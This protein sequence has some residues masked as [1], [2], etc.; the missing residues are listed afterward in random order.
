MLAMKT[1]SELTSEYIQRHP[2]IK[3]CL[4]KDLINYSSLSRLISRELRIDKKTSK[5]AILV[6]ARRFREKLKSEAFIEGKVHSLLSRSEIEVKNRIAVFILEKDI[7][8]DGLDS[9]QKRARRENSMFYLLEGSDNHTLITSEKYAELVESK[10]RIIKKTFNLAL[11]KLISPKEVEN[12]P[13]WVSYLT[14]LFAENGVNIQEFLSCW[15][16]TLFVIKSQEIG[17]ALAF[18]GFD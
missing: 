16:D 14:S 1:T 10:G 15:T 18:L 2:C 5:E 9:I 4:K 12:T 3:S 7:D 6:A 8:W 13:G 17:K 11:I